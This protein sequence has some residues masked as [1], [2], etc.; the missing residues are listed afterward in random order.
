MGLFQRLSR[1][2]RANLNDLVSKAED[3][4]KILDQAVLDM[5]ADLVK[6]RGAVAATMASQKRLEQQLAQ[7]E[8][9]AQEWYEKAELALRKENET[10][11]REALARKKT[12]DDTA[13]TLAPQVEQVT[14]QVEDLK[15]SLTLLER[16]IAEAKTKKAMLKARAQVAQASQEIQDTLSSINP[17]GAAAAFEGMEEKV[18]MLEARGQAAAELAGADLESQFAALGSDDFEGELAAMR[19]RLQGNPSPAALPPSGGEIFDAPL[20]SSER[21]REPEQMD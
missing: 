21:V 13:N 3:P 19:E 7:A 5:E 10:L 2:F 9:Q 18:L 15:R 11:A 20:A 1:L 8:R 16:K 17:G 6:M 14:R 12:Y 4:A